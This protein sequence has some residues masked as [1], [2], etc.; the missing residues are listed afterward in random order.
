MV[1]TRPRRRGTLAALVAATA[2]F[3]AAPGLAEAAARPGTTP[4]ITSVSPGAVPV[5]AGVVSVTVR[6]SGFEPGAA[7]SFVDDDADNDLFAVSDVTVANDTTITATVAAGTEAGVGAA[8]VTNLDGSTATF[9]DALVARSTAGEYH[10]ITPARVLDT[11]NGTGRPQPGPIHGGRDLAVVVSPFASVPAGGVLAVTLN[12][13][14]TNVT[15]PGFVTVWPYAQ[16]QPGTSNLN[17][18][19]ALTRAVLVTTRLGGAG[20]LDIEY[21]GLGKVDLIADVVGWYSV[22][23]VSTTSGPV[24]APVTP[25]RL[26]DTR[27]SGGPIPSGGTAVV[28]VVPPNRHV[29]AAAVNLTVPQPTSPGYVTAWAGGPR[30]PTSNLNVT[31]GITVSNAAVV[32]VAPDGTITIFMQLRDDVIVDLMG[33]FDDGTTATVGG[34]YTPMKVPARIADTRSGLGGHA[35]PLAP[36]STSS[37]SGGGVGGVPSTDVEAIT[38]TATSVGSASAGYFTFFPAGATRPIVSTLNYAPPHTVANLA[39]IPLSGSGAFSIYSPAASHA[40]VDVAGWYSSV[41]A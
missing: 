40:I 28:H 25:V 14:A 23:G 19:T 29:S 12:L 38:A 7:L 37:F 16:P 36:G 8:T 2:L 10:A 31:P 18:E 41:E 3:V 17:V 9:T 35:G 11:R 33:T 26:L 39:L 30:P 24:Y 32:P 13:T 5:P 21:T 34:Q 22:G 4:T 1:V 6:G 20:K 27:T 15:S